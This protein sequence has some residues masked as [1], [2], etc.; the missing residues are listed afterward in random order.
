MNNEKRPTNV[1]LLCLAI[2][3]AE[4]MAITILTGCETSRDIYQGVKHDVNRLYR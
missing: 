2:V 4:M 1:T 3:I